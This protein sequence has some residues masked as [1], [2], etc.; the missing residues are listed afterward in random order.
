MRTRIS[1]LVLYLL[2]WVLA[3]QLIVGNIARTGIP[4]SFL[5]A[6]ALAGLCSLACGLGLLIFETHIPTRIEWRAR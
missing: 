6:V 5:G 4:M 2:L 3:I 1:F